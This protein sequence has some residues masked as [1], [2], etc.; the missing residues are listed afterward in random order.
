MPAALTLDHLEQITV[1][2]LDLAETLR[3]PLLKSEQRAIWPLLKFWEHPAIKRA[4]RGK[5][6]EQIDYYRG[7]L[8]KL[9]QAVEPDPVPQ[10]RLQREK[11]EAV[12]ELHLGNFAVKCAPFQ[13]VTVRRLT[14]GEVMERVELLEH[15]AESITIVAS[16]LSMVRQR[17]RP[18]ATKIARLGERISKMALTFS[19]AVKAAPSIPEKKSE[20]E[21]QYEAERLRQLVSQMEENL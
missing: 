15:L 11:P 3:R 16:E 9:V 5:D 7:L 21:L 6:E 17:D 20:E 12:A 1:A 2:V 14:T 13:G 19:R 4:L 18:A 8:G 10:V